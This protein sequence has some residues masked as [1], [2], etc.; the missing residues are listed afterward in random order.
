[1]S[2]L[3]HFFEEAGLAT[4]SVSLVREHSER[5]VPPR[6]LWVPFEFGRPFGVPDDP[7]FQREVLLSALRLLERDAGPILADYPV[8]APAADAGDESWVCPV[9]LRPPPSDDDSLLGALA[10]EIATLTQWYEIARERRGATTFGASGLDAS[11]CAQFLGEFL[12]GTADVERW[13]GLRPGD[14]L[15][16][17]LMDVKTYYLEAALARPGTPTSAELENWFWGDSAAGQMFLAL[18]RK[19]VV[20]DDPF[21]AQLGK[22]FIVP[23]AQAHRLG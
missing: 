3:G 5:I 2:G 1:M 7:Q 11:G 17:V 14:V 8:D 23:R 13:P 22:Q 21:V 18:A 12:D 16:L 6:A 19:C 4:V 10:D 9:N 20:D 15:K